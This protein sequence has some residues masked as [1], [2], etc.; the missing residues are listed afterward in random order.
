MIENLFHISIIRYIVNENPGEP[1]HTL[2]VVKMFYRLVD[3][4]T[5]AVAKDTSLLQYWDVLNSDMN[6]N[7]NALFTFVLPTNVKTIVV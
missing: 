4:D 2:K 6:P 1:D 5:E 3:L 7:M